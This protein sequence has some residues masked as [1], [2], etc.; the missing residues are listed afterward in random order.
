MLSASSPLVLKALAVMLAA[1]LAL[2]ALVLTQCACLAA[3][4]L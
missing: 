1:K 2:Q 3:E 4:P